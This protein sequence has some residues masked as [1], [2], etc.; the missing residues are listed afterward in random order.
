M[1]VPL[2]ALSLWLCV[3]YVPESR[4]EKALPGFDIVGAVLAALALAGVTYWLIEPGGQV[5]A[6]AAGVVS[7][8][9]FV[10]V[11]RSRRERAMM[12]LHL[13]SSR[14]F[15]GLNI[16]TVLV[17]GAFGG[18]FFFLAIYLQNALGYSALAAGAAIVPVTLLMLFF[19]TWSGALAG[20]IGPR[21][22]LIAGPLLAG[23]GAVML[24]SA[25]HDYVRTV[26]PGLILFGIGLTLLVAPLTATVLAAVADRYAGL[27]SGVS[28]A[29][30]RAASML[31][32]AALPM[33]VGLSGIEYKDPVQ[34]TAAF[35][36]ARPPSIQA[37]A[38]EQQASGVRC[39]APRLA[40]EASAL[41][42][43]VTMLASMPTPQRTAPSTSAST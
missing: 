22:Q 15:S 23:L 16:Y 34:L 6:L 18:L 29:A 37:S 12:P 36:A 4:D 10:A 8:I 7:A 14:V 26:L 19:S 31:A 24:R 33:I 41:S 5:W 20:R 32:V 21:W 39:Q 30:A 13:F 35:Q 27:A 17:Y 2:A 9:A 43:A 42:D 28:N 25:G 3:K 40:A 1:N 11:E 38:T